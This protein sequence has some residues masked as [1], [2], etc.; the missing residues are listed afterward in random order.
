MTAADLAIIAG[1]VFAWGTC[2]AR[3]QRLNDGIATPFVLAAIA[4]AASAGHVTGI[5]P[6]SALAEIALGLASAPP[7]ARP[8]SRQ[9]RSWRLPAHM[10]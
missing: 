9:R 1:L 4:G 3:L 8:A 2:R 10:W 7:S 5:G 6:D